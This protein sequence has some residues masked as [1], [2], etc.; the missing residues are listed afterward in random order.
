[1]VEKTALNKSTS[2]T[3]RQTAYIFIRRLKT[4]GGNDE[5]SVNCIFWETVKFVTRPFHNPQQ[6]SARDFLCSYTGENR[7]GTGW[8]GERKEGAGFCWR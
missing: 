1:V 4:S 7:A 5:V 3:T 8:T 2:R 6:L